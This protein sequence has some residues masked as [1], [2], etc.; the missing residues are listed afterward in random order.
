M[1]GLVLIGIG[2][3]TLTTGLRSL[4]LSL[5][6]LTAAWALGT[7]TRQARREAASRARVE[8]RLRL[9]RDVHDVLSHSLGTIG[10]Q[11][12]VA[13]HVSTLD[14]EQLR[15][16]LREVET[17]A[18]ASLTDLKELLHRERDDG[19]E[20]P[21]P[22][23]T[24]ALKGPVRALERAGVRADFETTGDVAT[25]PVVYG[26]TIARFVQ[27]AS[28]NVIRHSGASSC[29]IRIS[30]QPDEATV[31]VADDGH[32]VRGSLREGHGLTGMRERIGLLDGTF[33]A[34]DSDAGFAVNAVFPLD[35]VG[36]GS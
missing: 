20:V 25:L 31:S 13:A 35:P 14:T 16:V 22:T 34:G 6:V 17:D 7:R 5:I 1:A 24:D 15:A 30:V 4:V 19:E 33:T 3:E 26:Q 32:G 21:I 18:R 27:E 2:A 36:R 12:G 10:V 29:R 23:L 9:S 11:A 8:E 28:T